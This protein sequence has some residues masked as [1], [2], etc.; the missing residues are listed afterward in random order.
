VV[1][2][3]C[4]P[5]AFPD[6][7][8]TV[9]LAFIKTH[10]DTLSLYE[11]REILD[12]SA[13][14]FSG[15]KSS[16]KAAS[17]DS[18]QNNYGYDDERGDYLINFGDHLAYRYEILGLLGKGSF[19][20]VIQCRDY[21]TGD[22]VAVKIIRNKKRFHQQALVEVR[23][24]ENL[25]QWVSRADTRFRWSPNLTTLGPRGQ[26]QPYQDCG[27][28]LVPEPFMYRD[29]AIESQLVRAR[30]SEQFRRILDR[31]DSTFHGANAIRIA[32]D[33]E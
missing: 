25:V 33:E 6:A 11:R 30:Q 18:S 26:A 23:I 13:I 14:W 7:H 1:L 31:L 29:R 4:I 20:Q 9:F 24:L 32:G 12:Y 10:F 8:R 27:K 21:K 3:L 28:V 16:K 5:P 2:R 17:P 22:C 15:S 19:G